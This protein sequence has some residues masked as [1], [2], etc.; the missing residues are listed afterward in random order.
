[1][2]ALIEAAAKLVAALRVSVP[3]AREVLISGRVGRVPEIFDAVTRRLDGAV[4]VR[5]LGGFTSAVK[6]AA[7]G[8]ALI[9][10][11]LAG[12]RYR[13]VVEAMRLRECHG[14]VLDHLYVAGA[15]DMRRQFGL[16]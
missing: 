3:D 6:E 10:D 11:G 12:G 9:A 7:Q 16:A 1:M 13:N 15:D 14:S 5:P 4:G 2:D 8:A